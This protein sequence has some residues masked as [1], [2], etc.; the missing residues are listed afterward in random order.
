MR[1]ALPFLLALAVALSVVAVAAAKT[2]TDGDDTKGKIDIKSATFSKV[3]GGKFK[4]VVV[5]FEDVPAKG[6]RGN[7]VMQV[8]KK[9]PHFPKGCNG[10][11]KEAP[12]QMQGPQTGKQDVRTNCGEEGAPCNKTGTG[13]IKRKGNKLTFIFSRKSVGKP[14]DKLFWRIVSY[15]YGNSDECPNFDDCTDYAPNPS[16][17][18]KESL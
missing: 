6:E 17:V 9:K 10:C 3:K 14:K 4:I 8:W 5:F 7:E 15:Y 11:F 2:V 12:Y 13:R 16:K 1:R 18:V